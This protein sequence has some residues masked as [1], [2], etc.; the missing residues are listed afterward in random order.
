MKS[1][2]TALSLILFLVAC[3]DNSEQPP[4]SVITKPI[5]HLSV[6]VYQIID[7]DNGQ[8][9]YEMSIAVKD[10]AIATMPIFFG[11]DGKLILP[12]E[13]LAQKILNDW[14]KTNARI[15]ASQ[16]ILDTK[17]NTHFFVI[18]Y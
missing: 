15:I 11:H 10:S 1:F 2:I 8:R 7:Q 5:A 3:Q 9:R 18:S 13:T 16:S 4:S 6:D 14:I 12:D 17:N